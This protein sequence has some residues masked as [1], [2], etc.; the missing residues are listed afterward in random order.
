[1]TYALPAPRRA[2][3]GRLR[4][5]AGLLAALPGIAVGLL[6]VFGPLLAGRDPGRIVADPYAPARA[7]LLMGADESGRDVFARLLAGGQELILVPV[8]ATL[9]TAVIGTAVGMAAGYRG[10]R[11]GEALGQVNTLFLALPPVLVLLVLLHGWGSSPYTLTTVVVVVGVPFVAKV[12]AA[13]TAQVRQNAYV[14]Q[15]SGMG[16]SAVSVLLREVLPNI[17]RPIL[18]DAGTRLAVAITL[19]ASASFLGFG[20]DGPNWGAMISLNYPGIS[21]NM[22]GV[23][24]PAVCLSMLTIYANRLLD[25]I[26]ARI[27]G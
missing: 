18:S 16:E 6:A 15:A 23:L 17:A 10:G 1:M 14:E 7:G 21:L 3:A 12:A 13:S 25:R 22:W 27:G 20:G 5:A 8:V 26:S 11:V 19:T 2:A 24:A 4:R 9:L